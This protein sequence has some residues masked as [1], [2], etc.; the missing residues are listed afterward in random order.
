MRVAFYIQI[1][2]TLH[3]QRSNKSSNSRINTTLQHLQHG[4]LPG[5]SQGRM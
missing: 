5:L 3:D 4:L 1:N 2:Q